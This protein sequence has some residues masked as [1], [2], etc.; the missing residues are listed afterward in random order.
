VRM[1]TGSLGKELKEFSCSTKVQEISSSSDDVAKV[2]KKA[3]I[4][5]GEKKKEEKKGK[6]RTR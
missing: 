4:V 6:A 5:G 2:E 3:E 1:E